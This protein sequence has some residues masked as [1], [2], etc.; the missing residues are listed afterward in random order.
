VQA[1]INSELET[2]RLQLLPCRIEDIEAAHNLWT[3]D[4]IRQYLF[5]DRVISL[6]DARS[7]VEASLA[8]FEQRGYGL[9][10]AF[11]REDR[12]LLGFA[13]FLRLEGDVPGLIYGVHPDCCGKGYATEAASAV[14]DY[15]LGSLAVPLVRADV[16]EPN[17]ISVRVL[18]KLGLRRTGHAVVAGRP[19]LYYE[20]SRSAAFPVLASQAPIS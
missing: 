11:T 14:L 12:S 3:N 4:H 13:G 17:V 18:E 6:D 20:K 9:W 8:N 1:P 16:D 2:N 5:D 7:Y 15:A 10:L 19:L